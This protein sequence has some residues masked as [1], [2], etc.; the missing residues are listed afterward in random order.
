MA[1]PSLPVEAPV[2]RSQPPSGP[3][4]VF[5]DVAIAFEENISLNG[6]RAQASGYP[7]SAS[8][9]R[10]I[11]EVAI[12]LLILVEVSFTVFRLWD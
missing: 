2:S 11:L 6:A 4:I 9:S 8:A 3:V 10:F 12:V 7:R 5:E 1:T